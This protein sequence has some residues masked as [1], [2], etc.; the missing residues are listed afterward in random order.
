MEILVCLWREKKITSECLFKVVFEAEIRLRVE[1][2]D[3]GINCRPQMQTFD[4]ELT[5]RSRCRREVLLTALRLFPSAG[6]GRSPG[7]AAGAGK[8]P[9]YRKHCWTPASREDSFKRTNSRR[10]ACVF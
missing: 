10:H 8:H 1:T 5:R 6:C 4:P 7:W 2:V 9:G 3:V